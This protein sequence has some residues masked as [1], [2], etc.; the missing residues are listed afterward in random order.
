[1]FEY[2]VIFYNFN[3]K[4]FEPYNIFPYFLRKYEKIPKLKQPKT[5][6][7]FKQFIIKEVQYQYWGR[8]EYEM[9]LKSW[10]CEDT[11]EK[12]DIYDQIMLNINNIVKLFM[13]YINNR[14]NILE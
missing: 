14:N 7:E 9:V 2:N 8:C 6:E 3:L 12:W 4:K 10:P 5:F 1:M 13:L 11:S